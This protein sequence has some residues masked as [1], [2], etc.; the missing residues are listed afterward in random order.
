M[1]KETYIY[2]D[3]TIYVG[4]WQGNKRHGRGIWTRP[5]GMKHEG[6]WEKDKPN[7]Q[8]T[9]IYPDGKKRSGLWENGKFIEGQQPADSLSQ[10]GAYLK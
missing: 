3:G 2:P 4:E 9:L 8:G 5:D 7:G 6:E 1:D 10:S